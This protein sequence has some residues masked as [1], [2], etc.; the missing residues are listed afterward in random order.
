MPRDSSGNYTLPFGN[1][2]VAGTLIEDSW[3]N[4][5]MEDIAAQLNNVITQD[6]VLPTLTE[7]AI[8][9]G[10]LTKPGLYFKL[11]SQSGFRRAAAG[12]LALTVEGED[13]LQLS[14]A[15]MTLYTDTITMQGEFTLNGNVLFTGNLDVNGNLIVDGDADVAGG[16]SFGDVVTFAKTPVSNIRPANNN[17]VANKAYVDAQAFNVA[18]PN[19]TG[20]FGKVLRTPGFEPPT[21]DDAWGAPISLTGA[22]ALLVRRAYDSD[23]TAGAFTVTLPASPAVGDWVIIRDVGLKNN[24]NNLTVDPGASM[25]YGAVQTYIMD[26]NGEA[27]LFVFDSTKGWV[28]G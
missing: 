11:E 5:T 21:W 13:L 6:G 2:V 27:I 9:D 4:P 19:P 15:S 3:A 18:L 16:G 22:Q 26:V 28:R 24:Q 20:A 7:F 1:P 14:K 23:T 25:V 10:V 12:V 17:E 8:V